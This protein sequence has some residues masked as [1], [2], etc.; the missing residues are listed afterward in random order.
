MSSFTTVGQ[1]TDQMYDSIESIHA[2]EDAGVDV[3]GTTAACEAA[4][5]AVQHRIDNPIE[6]A[7]DKEEKGGS[8]KEL[9][10][11]TYQSLE[12][13]SRKAVIEALVG[14][15]FKASTAST[16]QANMKKWI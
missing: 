1:M 6:V 5:V 16:Y 4:K 15:G 2:A 7:V 12:D 9:A 13:K 8:K 11:M 10:I 3:W 14:V